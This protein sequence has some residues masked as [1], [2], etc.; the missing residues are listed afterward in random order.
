MAR[1]TSSSVTRSRPPRIQPP[2]A[3]GSPTST[4]RDSRPRA[5]RP[6][7]DPAPTSSSPAPPARAS[8]ARS[9]CW[10]RNAI[11]I[12]P[13]NTATS[14]SEEMA[15]LR[16]DGRP[17]RRILIANRGEIAL[18]LIRACREMGIESV[19]VFS[20]VDAGMRHVRAPDQAVRIGPAPAAESYLVVE[21]IVEAALSTGAEAIHPGYGFLSERPALAEA[22]VAAGIVFIGPEPA[23]LHGLGDKLNARRAASAVGVPVVPGTLEPAPVDRPD[24][25]ASIGAEAER[26]GFPVVGKA[27]AGGGAARGGVAA[28]GARAISVQ[29]RPQK[30]VEEA[31][32]PGFDEARRREL[33]A[34]G[35]SVAR[36]GGAGNGAAPPVL[37]PPPRAAPERPA[38]AAGEPLRD[39]VL[40]AAEA[41]ATPDRH[42]IE[43]RLSAEDPARGFA[44]VPGTVGRWRPPGGPGVRMDDWIE[45]GT[46]VGG[47]YDPLLAKLLVVAEDRDM[48]LARLA[49]GLGGPVVTG[50]QTTVPFD[51]WLVDEPHFRA[52]DL[53]TGFAPHHQDPPPARGGWSSRAGSRWSAS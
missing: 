18:R 16:K 41:A 5:P 17:F 32:A 20:D 37:A 44:P 14:R 45:D 36:G 46:R 31:P 13:R 4:P 24:S 35:V 34:L 28:A 21:R 50:I 2:N 38:P 29:R 48:A 52:G 9:S 22:C 39:R 42:A 10:P 15:S 11:A 26:T 49:R 7:A 40:A 23:T 33:H 8:S 53:S 30:L 1:S 12:R 25:A 43:V 27:A 3:A 19:A 51:R 47:D 6:T